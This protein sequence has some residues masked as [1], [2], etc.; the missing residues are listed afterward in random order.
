M[1][2]STTPDI[3]N[4]MSLTSSAIQD[5]QTPP[6][7]D[8]SSSAPYATS[9]VSDTRSPLAPTTT[10]SGQP[11]QLTRTPLPSDE[12]LSP[13]G[14]SQPATSTDI[15]LPNSPAAT[16]TGNDTGDDASH[17]P[18]FSSEQSSS[19]L[20]G[21]NALGTSGVGGPTEVLDARSSA[22]SASGVLL[23][24]INTEVVATSFVEVS[25]TSSLII[26]T[27]TSQIVVPTTV[28]ASPSPPKR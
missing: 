23:V 5:T 4:V 15:S 25:G 9:L 12:V 10:L 19:G 6:T 1:T 3:L 27:T 17:I 14:A 16:S 28:P 26:V 20:L 7:S 13:S 8:I 11:P 24:T 2:A 21:G 18:K 22:I